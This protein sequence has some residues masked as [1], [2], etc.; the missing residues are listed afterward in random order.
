VLGWVMAVLQ[1]T[2]AAQ[3]VINALIRLGVPLV[4]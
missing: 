2:L 3:Y 4:F 1:A